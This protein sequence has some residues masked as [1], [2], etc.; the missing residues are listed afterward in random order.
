[1][2]KIDIDISTDFIKLDQLL[3]YAGIAE[4]GGHAKE[5]VQEGII[6]VNGELCLARGK[7]IRK[8]DVITFDDIIINVG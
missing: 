4:T 5:I 8:G 3:K 2:N 6:K 1:M 7:K